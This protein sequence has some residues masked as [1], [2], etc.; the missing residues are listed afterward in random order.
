MRAR[1]NFRLA[2][3]LERALQRCS[4]L[5][6]KLTPANRAYLENI[7]RIAK[8]D[9]WP[10]DAQ[11]DLLRDGQNLIKMVKQDAEPRQEPQR[12]E[13]FL[14]MLECAHRIPNTPTSEDAEPEPHLNTGFLRMLDTNYQV[15]VLDRS[16][17]KHGHIPYGFREMIEAAFP[18]GN[19]TTSE[20]KPHVFRR[21][22]GFTSM[23]EGARRGTE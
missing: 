23:L 21:S 18:H 8:S 11:T 5:Q 20:D 14:N 16:E 2:N 22:M 17:E 10:V 13:G 4:T 9:T 1:G 3:G 19:R 7:A 12:R 15:H 6:T